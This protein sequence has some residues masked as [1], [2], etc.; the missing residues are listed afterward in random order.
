MSPFSQKIAD[1][2]CTTGDYWRTFINVSHLENLPFLWK[3]L[4]YTLSMCIIIVFTLVDES[5]L[6]NSLSVTLLM[7]I[8]NTLCLRTSKRFTVLAKQSMLPFDFV[9]SSCT[10]WRKRRYAL[11]ANILLEFWPIYFRTLW[12]KLIVWK[13]LLLFYLTLGREPMQ[14]DRVVIMLLRERRCF[15]LPNLGSHSNFKFGRHYDPT[16]ALTYA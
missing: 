9:I 3:F 12:F 7:S 14:S 6:H 4:T 1:S 8:C 10:I 2:F 15:C 16:Q 13:K 11:E 5:T